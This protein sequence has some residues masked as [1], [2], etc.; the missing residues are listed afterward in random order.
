M[1][2]AASLFDLLEPFADQWGATGATT[3]GPISRYLGGLAAVLGRY[4]ET[5]VY[6]SKS[7]A[8]CR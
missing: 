6:F 4:E 3:T 5:E 2:H 1:E 7:A 8:F